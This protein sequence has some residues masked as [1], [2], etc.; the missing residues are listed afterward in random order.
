MLK[1]L[2]V[3][4]S[5]IKG[6]AAVGVNRLHKALKKKNIKSLILVAEKISADNDVIGPKSTLEI[7]KFLCLKSVARTLKKYV[8]K[9]NEKEVTFC[10]LRST[11]GCSFLDNA[12][13]LKPFWAKI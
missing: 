9:S 11:T 10:K 6:G 12:N 3:N 4:Y 8:L 7:I 13:T 2:H 1:I 5:D